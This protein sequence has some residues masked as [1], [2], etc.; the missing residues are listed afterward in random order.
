MLLPIQVLTASAR[1]RLESLAVESTGLPKEAVYM[2]MLIFMDENDEAYTPFN[3]ENMKQYSFD[4]TAIA[5][6]NSEGFVSMSCHY[7]DN[8]TKMKI[9]LNDRGEYYNSFMLKRFS[10]GSMSADSDRVNRLLDEKRQFRIA[11]LD[12]NG[13]IIQLS[14]PFDSKTKNGPLIDYIG[15]DAENNTIS[16][17][18]ENDGAPLLWV[19]ANPIYLIIGIWLAGA[20]VITVIIVLLVSKRKRNKAK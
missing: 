2:D 19:R 14:K 16:L 20:V 5:E 4:T 1:G 9:Q 6:Y 12:E 8:L 18:Y 10:D 3:E 17:D 13:S 15:Y 7:N 11:L